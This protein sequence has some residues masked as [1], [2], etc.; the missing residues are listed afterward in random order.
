ME[1]EMKEEVVI[2]MYSELC[3]TFRKKIMG[4]KNETR[5]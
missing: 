4:E 3:V 2:H 1:V 5:R